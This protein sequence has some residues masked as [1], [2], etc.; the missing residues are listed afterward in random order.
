M[1]LPARPVLARLVSPKAQY[2]GE[3]RSGVVPALRGY[4]LNNQD[5]LLKDARGRQRGKDLYILEH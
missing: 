5:P 2:A 4:S 3:L 1:S